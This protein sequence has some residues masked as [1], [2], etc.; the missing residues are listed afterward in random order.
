MA[1][2]LRARQAEVAKLGRHGVGRVIADEQHAG[3]ERAG[4]DFN[5]L[6]HDFRH[7]ADPPLT[8]LPTRRI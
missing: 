5:G 8:P 4:N 6:I 3:V 2:E 7:P 1:L